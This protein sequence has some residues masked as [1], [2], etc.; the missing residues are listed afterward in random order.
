[1]AAAHWQ[2]EGRVGGEGLHGA[3]GAV[4]SLRLALWHLS[5]ALNSLQKSRKDLQWPVL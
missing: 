4:P 5:L 3:A 2:G 1:M